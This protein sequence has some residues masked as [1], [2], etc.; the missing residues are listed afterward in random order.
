MPTDLITAPQQT[1][2]QVFARIFPFNL[3]QKLNKAKKSSWPSC[4][5][6]KFS[7]LNPG[8]KNPLFSFSYYAKK[9]LCNYCIMVVLHLHK[10]KYF[11]LVFCWM[12][13]ISTQSFQE[14]T[15]KKKSFKK[16]E[17]KGKTTLE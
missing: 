14:I 13:L 11:I 5:V 3:L 6:V 4:G 7:L 12:F 9:E 2:T 16:S 17:N 1:Q 15:S 10:A 8:L